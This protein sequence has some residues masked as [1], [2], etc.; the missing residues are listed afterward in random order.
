MGKQKGEVSEAK[1][2][3]ILFMLSSVAFG[4]VFSFLTWAFPF[5]IPNWFSPQWGFGISLI[6]LIILGIFVYR[7]MIPPLVIKDTVNCYLAYNLKTGNVLSPISL[8]YHYWF[9]ASYAFDQLANVKSEYRTILNN[10]ID[11]ESS[12]FKQY[13]VYA[14]LSWLG[15]LPS[16][17]LFSANRNFVPAAPKIFADTNEKMKR[18][19]HEFFTNEIKNEFVKIPTLKSLFHYIMLPRNFSL[20]VADDKVILKNNYVT[21]EISFKTYSWFRGMDLRLCD[22]LKIPENEYENYGS[23]SSVII[24]NAKLNPVYALFPKADKYWTFVKDIKENLRLE[25]DYPALLSDLKES[26]IWKSLTK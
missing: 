12:I 26:L 8:N 6:V 14:I 17:S 1:K 2:N 23:L 13:M 15:K 11:L 22:L 20:L 10:N 21:I 16:I 7:I 19:H 5:L 18:I 4:V 3:I 9:T 24:F 25:Y